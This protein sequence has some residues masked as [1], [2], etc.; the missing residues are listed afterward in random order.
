M[1][2]FETTARI[3]PPSI[4]TTHSS[5]PTLPRVGSA[6]KTA[7]LSGLHLNFFMVPMYG[8]SMASQTN[9]SL[10]L[11]LGGLLALPHRFAF[12]GKGLGAFQLVFAGIEL[13]H[14][15]QFALGHQVKGLLHG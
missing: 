1:L 9:S 2:G 15:S 14:G 7:D 6:C 13:V 11:E 3:F 10:W 8:Q 12:F 5:K 4:A